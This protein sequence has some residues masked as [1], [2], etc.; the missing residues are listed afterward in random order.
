MGANAGRPGGAGKR[1]QG[2]LARPSPGSSPG[3][4]VPIRA[5][6]ARRT[7]DCPSRPLHDC[8]RWP[9]V[10]GFGRNCGRAVD[11]FR[12][13]H[14]SLLALGETSAR[15]TWTASSCLRSG[16][17][18]EGAPVCLRRRRATHARLPLGWHDVSREHASR[19][20]AARPCHTKA[21][22]QRLSGPYLLR[23]LGTGPRHD[24]LLGD[25]TDATGV[26]H[27][28]RG[29]E[30]RRATRRL[31][32]PRAPLPPGTRG[33][34]IRGVLAPLRASVRTCLG[35]ESRPCLMLSGGLDS[36]CVAIAVAKEGRR[37]PY[38]ASG[39]EVDRS[40]RDA[41]LRRSSA[42]T[43]PSAGRWRE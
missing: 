6:K 1:G 7:S 30:I 5:G 29:V 34:G 23:D 4:R 36:A 20:L 13:R 22:R 33:R 19:H 37:M 14:R 12:R 27:F 38:R 21:T 9:I 26:H 35:G 24:R 16:T 31:F 43:P 25:P 41:R 11:R 15:R 42:R 8:P 10:L 32:A 40:T 17:T 3:T 18:S 39:I 28:G 2:D